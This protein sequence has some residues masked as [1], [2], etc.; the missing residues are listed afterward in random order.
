MYKRQ[1]TTGSNQSDFTGTWKLSE[2]KTGT[3][4]MDISTCQEQYDY[5]TFTS[6]TVVYLSFGEYVNNQCRQDA[7]NNSFAVVDG[8]IEMSEINTDNYVFETKY[9]IIEATPTKLTIQ[10]YW[11]RESDQQGNITTET[12]PDNEKRTFTY[13]KQ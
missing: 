1:H 5:L 11:V 13:L 9:H 3:S 10:L 4:M 2:W 6:S 7:S 8:N 12:L